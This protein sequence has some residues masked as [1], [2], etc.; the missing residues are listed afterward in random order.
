M[1]DKGYLSNTVGMGEPI[2][3]QGSGT[4]SCLVGSTKVKA[5][6]FVLSK[7]C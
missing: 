3:L 2:S 7:H 5:H 4:G 6:K 1:K